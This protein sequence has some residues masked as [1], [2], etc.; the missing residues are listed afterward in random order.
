MGFKSKHFIKNIL[1]GLIPKI[2]G[3]TSITNITKDVNLVVGVFST[4][5]CAGMNAYSGVT[6]K[7]NIRFSIYPMTLIE[8]DNCDKLLHRSKTNIFFIQMNAK[9]T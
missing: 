6:D 9:N 2:G 7:K 1:F 4:N 3:K 8:I 5:F